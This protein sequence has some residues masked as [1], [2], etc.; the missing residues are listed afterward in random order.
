VTGDPL[1]QGVYLVSGLA[2]PPGVL[3]LKPMTIE[4]PAGVEQELKHLAVTQR[5]DIGELVEEAIRQYLEADAITDL[6]SCA[7]GETQVKLSSELRDVAE[8]ERKGHPA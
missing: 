6:D 7:I 2:L 1:R 3:Y 5:R 8:V 4:L